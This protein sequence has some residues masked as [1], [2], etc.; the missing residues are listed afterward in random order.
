M[1]K[2]RTVRQVIKALKQAGFVQSPNHGKRTSHNR[3]IHKTDPTR[4]A[5]LSNHGS[6][7]V[8]AKG[9]LKS[10]ERTSGVEF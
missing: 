3:W 2:Q 9:T 8:L 6:G 7:D 5:D 10:M 1:G 4:Y